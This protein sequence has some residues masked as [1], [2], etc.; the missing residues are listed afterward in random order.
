MVMTLK[1]RFRLMILDSG[2]RS[3]TT[4]QEP[5]ESALLVPSSRGPMGFREPLCDPS[6]IAIGTRQPKKACLEHEY[7]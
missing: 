5:S 6:N 4:R 2:P 7:R 1:S 3:D